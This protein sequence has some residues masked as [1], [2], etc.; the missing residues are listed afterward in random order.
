[1]S[2]SS[3][4]LGNWQADGSWAWRL[5]RVAFVVAMMVLAARTASAQGYGKISGVV[6]DPAGAAV[7]GAKVTLTQV[8][9]GEITTT[10]ASGEGTFVFPSL[11]PTQYNL[12]ATNPGFGTYVQNGI[13]L[14]ADEAL[15]V[16]VSLKVGDAVETIT[17]EAGATQVDVSSATL[18]QVV[19][20]ERINDLPLNGRN[21][22]ALT[23]LVAGVVIAPNAQSDQGFTKTF[24]VV[25][26]V[27]AN[28]TRANQTN[29]ML[30][31]GNN[32]DEYTNVNAP[33][34]FPD[35]LQ[36]F[37][38]QTSNYNAEYG[39]NAGGVVNII[40]K[41]GT[42]TFH[43]DAFEYNR[44]AAYNA[45]NFFS[46]GHKVD[47]LKRNQ[48]GGTIGGPFRLPHLS[49]P[50]S[51]FFAGY[52][53]TILRAAPASGSAVV[54][55]QS[56]RNG[57]FNVANQS[58]CIKNPFTGATY[59]CTA[60]GPNPGTSTIDPTTYD[61]AAVALL[62]H[63]STGDASGSVLFR[64]PT[65]DD[66]HEVVGRF[67]HEINQNDKLNVRYFYDR[68]HRAGVLDTSN[69]LTYA[70]QATIVYQNALISETHLFSDRMLNNFILSYQRDHAAR[71]PLPGGI[72]VGDLGVNI[73][74]PAFKQINSIAVA[75]GFT[76]GDNPAAT[77]RR[78]NFTLSDDLHIVSGSHSLAFG[79]HG[80]LSKV[81]V[82]NQFRQP[83]AFSFNAQNS[84]NA[85]ASFLLG[86]MAN[87]QQASGQ[88]FN[89]RGKFFGFYGQDSWKV[90][91]RL[92]LNY[93][94]RYEPF[95]PW[96]EIQ[97]RMGEFSPS[98][99][100]AG[101]HSTIFP[102]APIG[103]L[104]TG[105]P[106]VPRDGIRPVYTDFMPRLGFAWDV[107]GTGKTSVR[108]G[109]GIFY[110]T[111]LSG[112]FNN[113][114]SNGSPFVT[115][116][117]VNFPTGTFSNP[118][119][120]LT[121]PFPAPQ[122]PPN[123]SILPPQPYL[124]FDPFHEFQLPRIYNWNLAIEQQLT[125]SSLARVAYVG[126]RG[127][128]L[129][130][131]IEL[132]PVQA[133]V[134]P[135]A[136]AYTQPITAAE[137][138]GSTS[139]HSLQL[140]YEQRLKRGMTVLANYTWSKALDD[141]PFGASVTAVGS[142]TSYVLP[143]YLP[144][145][146]HLDYGPSDFDHRNVFSLSYVWE[147]PKL[148]DGPAALRYIANGWQTNG[149]FQ[150]RSGDPLTVVSNA[151][152]NSG[153]GQNRD[154]AVLV[155][156]ADAYAPGSPIACTGVSVACRNYLNPQAFSTNPAGTFGTVNKGEFFGPQFANWDVSLMRYI[157]VTERLKV[158]LR[159]EYFN[160]LNHTNFFDPNTGLGGSFGRITGAN[161][162]RI[163][164]LSLKILF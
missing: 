112:V 108:G 61:P 38:V 160:V 63:L 9:T 162:P 5:V 121:N 83:G 104:F 133:G 130:V 12:T 45:A 15:T 6:T 49:T 114:F 89:N 21:A 76:I 67:D 85:I 73:W 74:Q 72:S 157:T 39:Q 69:L 106:G 164:Q 23:T 124:T 119:A 163:G 94:L 43:G 30:D 78:S 40:T 84:G 53:R 42:N 161:D 66:L 34:P 123:T 29:Y 134:R 115:T 138:S 109:T 22:A 110:D 125:H 82:D 140:T 48:F 88:F 96:H 95:F 113:I 145:F 44:N 117:N 54:P 28:G 90:N 92:T 77:F 20:Q 158:Q 151:P 10:T 65:N 142:G 100:A 152:N 71:G 24:P 111:R 58:Q 147:L 159:G 33:F 68:Y 75:S 36:E 156:G 127:N 7:P 25:V 62:S 146:K 50:H 98:A 51:F 3:R 2:P 137:Y 103:L 118:Y 8:G 60:V 122:P 131:P 149:I 14:Q 4:R 16:N 116:V 13:L 17:V 81:D 97:N 57:V 86:Y 139:Y 91:R 101:T 11:R 155:V 46:P 59:P 27:T 87:F 52:Q 128:H 79:F 129:W 18:S 55:T 154:R 64:K 35:A 135:F 41:S 141:L 144:D 26:T 70:D 56:Q 132:N 136:P 19:D 93:G 126:S 143:P 150:Y 47:P 1:M 120:G 148:K 99:F 37:S 32:V 31:G 102:N 153:T 107:F 80:E 105:D